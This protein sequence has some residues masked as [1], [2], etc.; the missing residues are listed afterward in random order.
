MFPLFQLG[1][2]TNPFSRLAP[3]SANLI[4][5]TS[6]QGLVAILNSLVKLTIVA[7][8]VYAF[9]NLILA[10]YVFL[11]AGGDPKNITKA[12][13]KIWQTLLGLM[14]VAGSF[15]LAAIFGWVIFH[16]ATALL[17]PRIYGP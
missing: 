11:S 3:G 4:S 12:W 15:V 17:T 7:A 5:S 1:T 6:G 16:D 14:V 8:G 13:D 10:G 9:F 2:V